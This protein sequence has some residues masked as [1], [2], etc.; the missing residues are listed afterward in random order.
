MSYPAD[1]L[2]SD[3]ADGEKHRRPLV[4]VCVTTFNHER[5]IR[6][7][8]LSVLAQD[9][10]VD[11]EILVGNDMS[12]DGTGALVD[13]LAEHHPGQVIH[14]RHTT[15]H[16]GAANLQSLVARSR[17]DFVAHLDGDDYWLPG[18]LRE[19]LA[20][21]A[22]CPEA[23]AVYSN[24]IV[25][26]CDDAM[27]GTFNNRLDGMFDLA[28]ILRR[29]NFLNHSSLLYRGCW[30]DLVASLPAGYLDYNVHLMLAQYGDLAY[31]GKPLVVYRLGTPTSVIATVNDSIRARYWAAICSVPAGRVTDSVLTSAVADFLRRVAFRAVRIRQPRLFTR[32]W[33]PAAEVAP[34]SRVMLAA[35]V[36]MHV[37]RE[38]GRQLMQAVGSR[39]SG[40]PMRVLYFR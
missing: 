33:P 38:L 21:L 10:A 9:A 2:A 25:V 11:L 39:L 4:S 13:E 12:E 36:F 16:G 35:M 20:I 17:G 27:V 37:I 32:W 23:A 7:C 3:A 8:L 31:V 19:Q 15:R 29:G 24:A 40:T 22:R 18:K 30:R 26:D 28:A 6:A 34:A 5:Y 14:I 1:G